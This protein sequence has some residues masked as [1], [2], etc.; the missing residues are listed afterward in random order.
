MH[1]AAL[2]EA[3]V[4]PRK[5]DAL[6]RQLLLRC[7]RACRAGVGDPLT[8]LPSGVPPDSSQEAR[9]AYSDEHGIVEPG[10]H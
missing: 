9:E 3:G 10:L 7:T 6:A 5:L 1:G 4:Q 2:H 8:A